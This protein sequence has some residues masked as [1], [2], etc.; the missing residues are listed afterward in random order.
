MRILRK[1]LRSIWRWTVGPR[2][3][4][5]KERHDEAADSL[6]RQVRKVLKK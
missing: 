3:A 5:A 4:A 2:L 6:D 1:W